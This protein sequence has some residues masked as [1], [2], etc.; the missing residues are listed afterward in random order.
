MYGEGGRSRNK[1]LRE[2]KAGPR[3][4]GS[5]VGRAGDAGCD[6]RLAARARVKRLRF[7]KVTIQYGEPIKFEQVLK[8]T[9]EQ[10]Q[11]AS[12]LVFERIR[13]MYEALQSVGRKGVCERAAR[14]A[15]RGAARTEPTFAARRPHGARVKRTDQSRVSRRRSSFAR[16][17]ALR[18]SP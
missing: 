15:P 14:A 6:P 4:A 3:P 7:P 8:P 18:R 5:G 9:R 10:A 12:V 1:Q 16:R 2:P 17:V 11:R 13:E